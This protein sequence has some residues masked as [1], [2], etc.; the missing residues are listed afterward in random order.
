MKEVHH[1]C[2]E[3]QLKEIQIPNSRETFWKLFSI[4]LYVKRL[5]C[6]QKSSNEG[7]PPFMSRT[8]IKR[9][10]D[11]KFPR[12]FLWRLFSISLYVKRLKC[13]QKPSN[14]GGP[15]FMSRN[16]MKRNTNTKFQRSFLWRLFSIFLGY[17]T[18][19]ERFETDPLIRMFW[20]KPPGSRVFNCL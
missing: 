10:T 18:F 11:T 3:P 17:N 14:E 6:L 13:V 4:S 20:S 5:K 16:P 9:N 2:Q 12:N 7:G 1:L 8:P 19:L 15:P